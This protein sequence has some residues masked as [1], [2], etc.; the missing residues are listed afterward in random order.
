MSDQTVR[1]VLEQTFADRQLS[2]GERQALKQWL[3]AHDLTVDQ[4][5]EFRNAAFDLARSSCPNQ[6]SRQVLDWLHDVLKAVQPAAPALDLVEAHFSPGDTCAR[7]IISLFDQARQQVDVCVFTIT[8]DRIAS[9][10]LAAHERGVAL[11]IVTD[12]EKMYDPGSDIQRL[13]AAG[14]PLRVDMTEFHMHHKFAIF[15][16]RLLLTGSYNWTRGAAEKNEEN[17]VI[18]GD[19]RLLQP[20]AE[21]FESLWRQLGK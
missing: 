5:A 14:I 19:R 18:T 7:R 3:A 4:V 21:V 16:R 2:R 12:N 8:D 13:R 6:D 9:A 15:D 10:I 1:E 20:F 11:R 17:F